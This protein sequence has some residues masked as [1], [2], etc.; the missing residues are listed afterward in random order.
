MAITED[1]GVY[2]IPYVVEG[3]GIIYND[4][5]MKKYFAL[6]DKKVKIS[7]ANE[8]KNFETLKAVVEDMQKNKKA[9]G[10]KGVFASTSLSSGED[11]RWQTHLLN[12]PLYYEFYEKD[13]KADVSLSLL[14]AEEIS[15]KY[16]N[17]Y[18]NIFDLYT[19]NS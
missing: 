9:L 3:Y 13:N 11:W 5:I 10:I 8:I 17:N 19:N 14:D 15:F 2:A 4:A 16:H 7:S 18:K 12:I 1:G 6:K